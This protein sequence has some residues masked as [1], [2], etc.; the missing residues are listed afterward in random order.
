MQVMF[1]ILRRSRHVVPGHM[2]AIAEATLMEWG[3]L[4]HANERRGKRHGKRSLIL[5]PL[6]SV[7]SRSDVEGLR[8]HLAEA[9][10]DLPFAVVVCHAE[11]A[12]LDWLPAEFPA[13]IVVGNEVAEIWDLEGEETCVFPA[14]DGTQLY[15]LPARRRPRDTASREAVEE[16]L[17]AMRNV[18][19]EGEAPV[20]SQQIRVR[21]PEGTTPQD[22]AHV[23]Y[24]DVLSHSD[25]EKGIGGCNALMISSIEHSMHTH[26][27]E[28]REF[29]F[30]NAG[31]CRLRFR[32]PRRGGN[33]LVDLLHDGSLA[34]RG[35]MGEPRGEHR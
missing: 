14:D 18:P 24:A 20:E 17:R 5:W 22:F 26:E 31:F 28:R 9:C 32:P 3:L 4:G 11:Q 16:K 19:L 2:S 12:L 30:V 10:D 13:S 35:A 21:L 1:G 33:T 6:H 15:V 23:A 34:F 25:P 29:V 27:G 8:D 7:P